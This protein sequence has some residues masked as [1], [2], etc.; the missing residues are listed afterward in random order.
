MNGI[1]IEKLRE[2]LRKPEPPKEECKGLIFRCE[3]TSWVGSDNDVN[4]KE[5]YRFIK[6]A[7][8]PG[9][10]QCGFLWDDLHERTCDPIYQTILRNGDHGKLYELKV[11][12]VSHDWETGIVDDW[13]I[14]F[15]KLPEDQQK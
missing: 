7:S 12:G 15:V 8:C 9:C 2:E 6:S 11:T 4:F 10:E 13:D 1:P 5:R 3:I 14:E